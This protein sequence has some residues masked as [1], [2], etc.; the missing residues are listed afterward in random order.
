M[1]APTS[2]AAARIILGSQSQSRHAI[3]REM[4]YKDFEVVTAGID[5]KSIRLPKAEDLVMTLAR[6]KA[7]AILAKLALNP[8]FTNRGE[9]DVPVL[10][11]TADQV[12]VHQGLI[13]EKPRSAEEAR[14]MIRGYTRAPAITVGSVLVT[15]LSTGVRVGGVDKAEVYFNEIPDEVIEALLDEGDVFYTAGGLLVEHPLVSPLVEAMVGT[16]DSVMGM[17]KALTSSLIA[18]ALTPKN[19]IDKDV[20]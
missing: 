3:L 9:G 7:E 4:G 2:P 11:I 20:T 5:E 18:Q 8:S 6:A 15:N 1:A 16:I 12:V 14:L 13:L 17:S 19:S 10:L